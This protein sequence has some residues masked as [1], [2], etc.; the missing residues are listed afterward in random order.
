M[1][2]I[3]L[4]TKERESRAPQ[5]EVYR[6]KLLPSQAEG[7]HN[8]EFRVHALSSIVLF[9]PRCGENGVDTIPVHVRSSGNAPIQ[10]PKHATDAKSISS[11]TTKAS[12]STPVWTHPL[13]DHVFQFQHGQTSPL[14]T[15]GTHSPADPSAPGPSTHQEPTTR[16][17]QRKR[18]ESKESTSLGV[19]LWNF[20]ESNVQP[21]V[22]QVGESER[23]GFPFCSI[24]GGRSVMGRTKKQR[25]YDLRKTQSSN[26]TLLQEGNFG[27]S[28]RQKTCVQILAGCNGESEGKTT[29][30]LTI[31]DLQES[32]TLL[33]DVC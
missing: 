31:K 26:E 25:K 18:K 30:D 33:N 24:R 9:R 22:P 1:W 8:N 23:G 4:S 20:D 11:C 7:T 27:K 5:S 29:L 14:H 17:G 3:V 6:S 12:P 28:W 32:S 16:W 15:R 21:S 13:P 10:M 19:H 2:W